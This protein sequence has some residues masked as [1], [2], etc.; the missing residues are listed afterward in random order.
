ME[1]RG[2]RLTDAFVAALELRKHL[3]KGTA[4]CSAL[5]DLKLQIKTLDD[6]Y[7]EWHPAPYPFHGM[8]KLFIYLEVTGD[9]YR[10][11]TRHPELA[12]VFELDRIPDESV[13]SRTWRNRFDDDIRG[14]ITASAHCLVKEVHNED[15]SVPEVRP[16]EE[17][18]QSSE[19]A[20]EVPEGATEFSDEEIYRTTRLAR[21][22]GFSP[23]DSERA[24]NATYEDTRFFELQTFIGMVRC[25]TPQGAARFK[26]RRGTEYGP[27]GD[28][29][30][31]TVKQ[32]GPEN[33]LDGFQ[34]ATD[35][36]LSVIGSESSFRRPVTVAIDITTIPYYGD[37][38]G[39]PMV[40]GTADGEGSA[41]KFATLSIVGWNIPVILAVEPVQES[42][43]WGSEPAEPD[44][45]HRSSI[46]PPGKGARPD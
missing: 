37:V 24:Q 25:G 28:T 22:H 17:V 29:H 14:Y 41:F 31:R 27:H 34:Q 18:K 5:T 15:L 35:R 8:L 42:S 43:S 30:L 6:G 16:L 9:S 2:R 7:P 36:L 3:R 20:T 21:E 23:F 33:L 32:F 46:A 45:P 44:S 4:F 12:D 10:S 11:L 40:S 39:M 26:F 38:D 1:Q 13:V 19:D